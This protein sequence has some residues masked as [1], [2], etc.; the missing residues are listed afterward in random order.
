M[1]MTK[2]L[3][4]LWTVKMEA[5]HQHLFNIPVANLNTEWGAANGSYSL[6]NAGGGFSRLFPD[7]LVNGGVGRNVGVEMTLS[8]A[9]RD[10]WFVLF[11]GSVFD[12]QYQGADGEVAQHRFQ[13]EIRMEFA[14]F[15]GMEA[16]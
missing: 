2:R 6:I 1:G 12:A 10:G 14:C 8:R 4:E 13:R 16:V 7:T 5:Y 9:F 3:K 11:T 15:K